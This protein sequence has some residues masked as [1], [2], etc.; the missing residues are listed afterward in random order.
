MFGEIQ[1][2]VCAGLIVLALVKV[3]DA[4]RPYVRRCL[5]R[6]WQGQQAG[7]VAEWRRFKALPVSLKISHVAVSASVAGALITS[8]VMGDATPFPIVAYGAGMMVLAVAC[9][10]VVLAVA[11]LRWAASC[12]RLRWAITHK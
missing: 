11:G 5:A 4:V 2:E 6:V 3:W 10:P 8:A 9:L 12:N 1:N 7:C